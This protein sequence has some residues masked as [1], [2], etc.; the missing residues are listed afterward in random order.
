[1]PVKV[2][3]ES[4][5]DLGVLRN[6]TIAVI[7]YG[8]QG[9]A[10]AL[11]LKESGMNVIVGLRKGKSWAAA[12]ND[13]QTVLTVAEAS[14]AADIIMILV[15]DEYQAALYKDEIEPHL[16]PGNAIA[17]G[18]GFNIH[19]GQIVPPDNI[20]VFMVAP[21]GPGHLVRRVYME[22]KGVPCLIAIQQN[23]TG[24]AKNIALAYA[25][26]IGGTRA[27]VLETTFQEETETDLFG[28]QTVL[29]GGT[30]ALVKAAFETL[31]DAG[32]QPEIAYF[33]C[34]HE[35][36]L[37]VDLMYEAGIAG[38]RYSIS[39][40]AQFGDM[41][42]G[43]KIID[44]HVRANMKETLRQIQSGEFA[45]E[46]ILENRAGRP[47]FRALDK[48]DQNHQIEVVGR[49]LRAMMSWVKSDVAQASA[50]TETQT[51]SNER[52]AHVELG[53]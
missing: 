43:P 25:R 34:L 44:D 3:Y 14:K 17:F 20:D 16:A 39:D 30:T 13:G 24:D 32:Y 47:V 10:H 49:Q 18:H 48:R 40:T 52:I 33:E 45:R 37:I 35:L 22:G 31:V 1:M 5:A 9:H 11:N 46:W 8:S 15:N 27:G 6:K 28:E 19:F 26:G 7:G 12:E 29:C 51:E 50:Q 53:E 42:R 38:M 4:D 21:K 2:Y 23:H 36:K 41:T